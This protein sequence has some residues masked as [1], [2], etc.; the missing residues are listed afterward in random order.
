[1]GLSS[2]LVQILQYAGDNV[3]SGPLYKLAHSM[4]LRNFSAL[5]RLSDFYGYLTILYHLVIV[6]RHDLSS[7][8]SK[9]QLAHRINFYN[10]VFPLAAIR[11]AMS[12]FSARYILNMLMEP[13]SNV[14]SIGIAAQ[15]VFPTVY[16]TAHTFFPC[17][18]KP[19]C[20]QE[21]VPKDQRP[22][23]FGGRGLIGND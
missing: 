17:L 18:C 21:Y 12:I 5:S 20:H 6:I 13:T 10:A 11:S 9:H 14:I 19:T 23:S 7:K 16:T 15:L 1:M 3:L 22:S 2:G 8:L 4:I